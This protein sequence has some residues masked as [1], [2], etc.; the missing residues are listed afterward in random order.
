MSLGQL[1]WEIGLLSNDLDS[2]FIKLDL[3]IDILDTNCCGYTAIF[4]R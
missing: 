2:P 3:W 1:D 4:Q